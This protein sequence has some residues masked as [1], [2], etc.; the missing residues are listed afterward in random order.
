MKL[1][2][3]ILHLKQD[4]ADL[5]AQLTGADTHSQA[6]YV[7]GVNTDGMISGRA[8]TL[9]YTP[10]ILGPYFLENF[11]ETVSESDV[12]NG[13]FQVIV[14]GEAYGSGSSREV[15]VVAHRGAGIELVVA[16]SFQRI[17]QENMVYSGM[18]FTTDRGILTPLA[19]GEDID[20]ATLFEALPPFFRSVAKTGG[21]MRYGTL[22][23]AGEISPTYETKRATRP[24][25]IVEKIV[26]QKAWTGPNSP[27]G[28]ASVSPGDQ[29]LARCAFRGMHEYTAGMVV[30]LYQQEWGDAPMYRPEMVAAFEDHFVLIDH[31][32]V[33]S[34]VKEARLAPAMR[35]TEEMVEACEKNGIRLHG[36]GRA[37]KSGVCHRIV[38]EDYALPGDIIVLTDSH[39]PTAGVMNAFAFGVG[40][41]AMAFALRTGLMP[42]TV[43]KVVRIEVTG[44]AKGGLSAKD[45][46][47]HLIGDDYFREEHWRE[48]PTDTC[49]I[50]FGGD[51]LNQWNVDELSVLTNMT[52]EGGLMTG[53][54]APC[55]P[56]KDFLMQQRGCDVSDQ[57]VSP[58]EGASY[59][60]VIHIHL[61]DVPLTV[62]TPGDSRNRSPLAKNTDV[63]IHN[64]VI[65]SCTGGSLS[66]LRAA[67]DVL[68][69][70]S[71]AQ[72]VR[73]T[74][75][76]SSADV[77][78]NAESE[79]LLNLFRGLGAVVTEP[80]CGSCIGNGPGIP[81]DGET[82]AST[83]NRNFARR[84]GG[85]GPVYLVSPA[86]AAA[87]AITGRLTDPRSLTE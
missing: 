27:D 49:I 20:L 22:L 74:V 25:N 39:S 19:A 56:I 15:A 70:K 73:L 8:C 16:D 62:A 3:R 87:S 65:A 72:G 63:A 43:P 82:T 86:V 67:A 57:L 77:A 37:Y 46:I 80:G 79:G 36:P 64:V 33:P 85:P 44:E 47:L 21:L 41:T 2:G 29:V 50:E 59:A 32:T 66:D 13:G 42:V 23:C 12:K 78:R 53:I 26:A 35:L 7:Y 60:K 30:D 34:H 51:G 76:P 38:V 31:E 24:M 55:Q 61:D 81:L 45:L 11:L 48:T 28:I 68:R 14:G 17:F 69:G 4:A 9:G 58:D 10:D 1:T 6:D 71:L 75:T 5:R 54:V 40:S 83:T 18:P 84:M 52:V